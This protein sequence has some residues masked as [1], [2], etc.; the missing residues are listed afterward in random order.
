MCFDAT[1][2]KRY[3]LKRLILLCS[4]II[5]L[6]GCSVNGVYV[7]SNPLAGIAYTFNIDGTFEAQEWGDTSGSGCKSVGTWDTTL[8]VPLTIVTST[9]PQWV[10]PE[11]APCAHFPEKETW[12]VGQSKIISS[13]IEL[14]K[15][16]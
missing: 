2:E 13:R 5:L 9:S 14:R 11:I 12:L 16:I 6:A 1:Q 10:K 4:N 15:K 8:L 3:T 7:R